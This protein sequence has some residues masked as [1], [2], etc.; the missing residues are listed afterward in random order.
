VR[1]KKICKEGGGKNPRLINAGASGKKEAQEIED[2]RELRKEGSEKVEPRKEWFGLRGGN[3]VL[4]KIGRLRGGCTCGPVTSGGKRI[5]KGNCFKRGGL[6]CGTGEVNEQSQFLIKKGRRIFGGR[7]LY[8][9]LGGESPW[10]AL[11]EKCKVSA[12]GGKS[13]GRGHHL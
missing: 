8:E 2:E 1:E 12:R 7:G 11:Q 5:R 9:K 13:L 3:A 6:Q 10:G 4:R